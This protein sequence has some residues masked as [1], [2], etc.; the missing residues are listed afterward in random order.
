MIIKNKVTIEDVRLDRIPDFDDRSRQF[1]IKA[2]AKETDKVFQAWRC[3]KW[4]DQGQEGACVGFGITHE[5]VAK[6]SIVP[7]KGPAYARKNIYW[8][9]QKIDPWNGGAYPGA[10][11]FYEGTS[12]LAGVKV[13][14]K[15]G[16]FESYRWAF[17][18]EDLI[19]GILTEGPAVIGVSWFSG[20]HNIDRNKYIHANGRVVGGHCILCNSVHTKKKRFNLHN[21]W[22]KRWGNRGDAYISFSDMDKLL[23]MNGEAVFFIGRKTKLT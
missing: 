19:Q 20:M 4:L 16:W 9:A 6:P 11:P 13:A 22:G 1:P 2:I 8:E 15:L 14:H 5:L 3:S 7:R 17:G 18:I 21:S 12:V 10:S 23:R